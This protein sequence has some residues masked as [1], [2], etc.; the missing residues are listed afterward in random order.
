M[1]KE[2]SLVM[3]FP[4]REPLVRLA[5]STEDLLSYF[6]DNCSDEDIQY[7]KGAQGSKV[8]L[9]LDGWDELRSSCRGEDMFFPKLVKGEILPNCSIVI[10]S[11]SGPTDFIK[12]RAPNPRLIEVLGFT[13]EQIRNYIRAYFKQEGTPEDGEKLLKDLFTIFWSSFLLEICSYVISNLFLGEA[14]HLN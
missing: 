5:E 3:C 10:T 11:R 14:Q 9:I 12:H 2:Y 13:Q 7:V 8:L 6:G 4:L 1:L